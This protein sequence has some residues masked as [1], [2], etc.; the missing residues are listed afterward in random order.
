MDTLD[1][2]EWDILIDGTGLQQSLLALALSRS[3][4]R[5]LHVDSNDYYGGDEAAMSLQDA[6]AWVKQVGKSGPQS[7]YTQASIPE[8]KETTHSSQKLGFSRAYS[9]ALAPQLIYAESKLLPYLVSSKTYRQLEFL[10]MGSWW[11]FSPGK[12]SDK[13]SSSD[14]IASASTGTL[15]RIPTTREDVVFSDK[16][17]DL[18]SKRAVI[19]I[20]R[21]VMDYENQQELWEPYSSRP[22]SDFLTEQFKLATTLHGLFLALTLSLDPPNKTYTSF[23]LP[24]IARHLRSTGKLGA[25]FSSVIPK[26]GGLSEIAQ[27]ACRAGAVGG[28]VYVL[29]KGV[30]QFTKVEGSVAKSIEDQ[31]IKSTKATVDSESSMSYTVK[32]DGD[33]TV[34][35][36]WIA[37]SKQPSTSGSDDAV[38][39]RTISRSISIVSSPLSSLF[40]TLAEGSP[41]PSGSVVIFPSDSLGGYGTGTPPVYLI[42]HSSDTGECP[43]G[44]S[45]LYA[46]TSGDQSLIA[47]AIAQVIQSV[48][49]PEKPH[50]LWQLQYQQRCDISS[51]PD[52]VG[53][54]KSI[55]LPVSSADLAFDETIL[56]SVKAAWQKITG[57]QPQE[58]LVFEDRNPV[59][60]DDDDE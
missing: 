47:A 7:L 52:D 21:F 24:R 42:I 29:A 35:T 16:S 59:G 1:K 36:E 49:E 38:S 60:D 56:D 22:F 23:A 13:P 6:D 44:Q 15:M 48:G 27:V 2:T 57:G 37:G 26:W 5:I 20:L 58:F 51:A 11:V 45:V 9:L 12:P 55:S 34:S 8:L 32:L 30:K 17:I 19:K 10:A 50:I 46:T 33:D 4:K 28:G 40:P 14:S 18:R 43:T 25:G 54:G 41:P 53:E 31:A 39:I 3:D